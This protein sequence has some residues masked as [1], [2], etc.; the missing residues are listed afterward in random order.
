[1]KHIK[2]IFVIIEQI[3]NPHTTGLKINLHNNNENKQTENTDENKARDKQ[4]LKSKQKN[5][6]I[7]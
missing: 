4:I 2:T 7:L 6:N 1:M 5:N 3:H